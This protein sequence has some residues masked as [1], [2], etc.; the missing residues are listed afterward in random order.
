MREKDLEKLLV[1]E[2]KKA[3]GSAYKFISPGSSGVPDRIVILPRKPLMFVELKTDKGK[4]TRL[5]ASQID[6]LKSLGQQV[7]VTRGLSGLTE[8]FEFLGLNDSVVKT[9]KIMERRKL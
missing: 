1:G 5:Q 7:F 8:F 3:G 2:I 9:K 6:K 4:L